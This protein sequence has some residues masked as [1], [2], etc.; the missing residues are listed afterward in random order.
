MLKPYKSSG[1]TV[2]F[3]PGDPLPEK[4]IALL[5]KQRVED[6]HMRW[7]EKI[8]VSKQSHSPAQFCYMGS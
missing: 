2:H 4:L 3:V 1:G 8:N 6:N 5:V 7:L